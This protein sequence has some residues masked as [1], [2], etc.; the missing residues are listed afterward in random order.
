MIKR[1]ERNLVFVC[2]CPNILLFP[3][4]NRIE[5]GDV[6][7]GIQLFKIQFAAR[8]GLAAAL[9]GQPCGGVVQSAVE[10][11]DFAD[12]AATAAQL[13]AVVHRGR[14]K[15]RFKF[16]GGLSVGIKHFQFGLITRIGFGNQRGGLGIEF[17]RIERHR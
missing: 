17:A 4:K 2:I 8:F 7:A 3:I 13:D 10:R 12:M 11:F 16:I 15:F 6:A 9:S 1:I 14:A 5:F